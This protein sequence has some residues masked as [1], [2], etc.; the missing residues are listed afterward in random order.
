MQAS[1][2]RARPVGLS[3]WVTGPEAAILDPVKPTVVIV[4]DDE[5]FRRSAAALLELRGYRVVGGAGRVS[6]AL[7]L[8]SAAKPQVVLLDIHLPDGDGLAVAACLTEEPGPRPRVVLTSSDPSAASQ[9]LVR[10]SGAAGFLAK[11][12]LG[13]DG[14]DDLLSG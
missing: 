13:A 9:R 3:P 8:V 12:D 6:D 14:L 10:A 7:A 4:D 5:D 2:P 11:E 1:V